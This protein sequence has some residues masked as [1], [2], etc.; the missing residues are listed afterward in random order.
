MIRKRALAII[1]KGS[2]FG[3]TKAI[4]CGILLIIQPLP[5]R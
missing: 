4:G 3:G 1:G 2:F 5:P